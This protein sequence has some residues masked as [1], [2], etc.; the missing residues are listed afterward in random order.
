MGE[1]EKEIIPKKE[2]QIIPWREKSDEAA[3]EEGIREG[4]N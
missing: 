4:R 3:R 1:W 2:K